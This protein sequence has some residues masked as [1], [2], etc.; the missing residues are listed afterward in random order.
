[1]RENTSC[2]CV[3]ISDI[4]HI[5]S[6]QDIPKN[7]VRQ[8]SRCSASRS[9]MGN[10]DLFPARRHMKI[11]KPKSMVEIKGPKLFTPL[12]SKSRLC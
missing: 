10:F 12:M 4:K 11:N 2:M 9:Q 1:M 6:M 5:S 7:M 3:E 8:H